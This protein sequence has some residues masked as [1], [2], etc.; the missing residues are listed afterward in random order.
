M[1]KNKYPSI[2]DDKLALRCN[3]VVL[4]EFKI[5]AERITGKPYTMVLRDILLALVSN[6]LSIKP[7]KDQ[8][9][10]GGLYQ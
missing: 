6:R 7:T 3:S 5:K 10:H 1:S 4:K 9:N 8:K 2:L